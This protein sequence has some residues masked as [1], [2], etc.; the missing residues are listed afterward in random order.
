MRVAETPKG[1][2]IEMRKF[3]KKKVGNPLVVYI[4]TLGPSGKMFTC[5]LW[6]KESS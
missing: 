1:L 6:E 2:Q 3:L 5:R 4:L